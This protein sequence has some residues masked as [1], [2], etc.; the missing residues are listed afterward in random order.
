[1]WRSFCSSAQWCIFRLTGPQQGCGGYLTE[2]SKSFVSPDHDSDGLYDKGLN[3]IWY[4]I[5]PENKLVKLT[6]NAFTL[7]EPSSPGKCTF[8]YVQVRLLH[9]NSLL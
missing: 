8:D 1:M 7:E 2:D 6:F 4:I 9:L 5:A 3:C